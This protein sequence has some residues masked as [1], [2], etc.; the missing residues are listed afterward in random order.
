[1]TRHDPLR[2]HLS[3][4]HFTGVKDD[5]CRAG[6]CYREQFP[7]P[8]GKGGLGC[9]EHNDPRCPK[10][11]WPTHEEALA[12]ARESIAFTNRMMAPI[13]S[14]HAAAK[15]AGL[16]KGHGGTGECPC[17]NCNGTL[18][19]KVAALNGHLWGK[20]STEGCASWME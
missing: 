9:I 12:K 11:E 15:A 6:V 5:R 20:C 16:G 14:A 2:F 7:P 10:A 1:M 19:Y 17:P 13:N 18:R 3:C 4:K 8:W